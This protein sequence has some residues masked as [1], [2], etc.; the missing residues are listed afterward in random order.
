[1]ADLTFTNDATERKASALLP[2]G[3]GE[4]STVKALVVATIE[5]PASSANDT[6]RLGRISSRARILRRGMIA[7]DDL[8][9][10]GAPTLDIGLGSVDDNITNDP[11]ALRNGI[12]LANAG[13]TDSVITDAA[14]AGKYAWELVSGLTS[15]PGGELDVYATIA[16]AATNQSGTLTVE[17]YGYID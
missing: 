3:I 6:I 14:D 5:V 4:S 16:D 13:V 9:T 10:S 2:V 12:D 8:A 7:N 17:I 1:M 15:D 11:D